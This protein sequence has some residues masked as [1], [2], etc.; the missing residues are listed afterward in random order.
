MQER[1]NSTSLDNHYWYVGAQEASS[2]AGW[3]TNGCCA[4]PS[5]SSLAGAGGKLM[6]IFNRFTVPHAAQ[7]SGERR[8]MKT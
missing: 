5:T 3:Y 1:Y 6:L 8:N 7:L 2:L 4:L